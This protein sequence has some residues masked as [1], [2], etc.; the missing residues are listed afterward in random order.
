[1]P[2]HNHMC[3]AYDHDIVRLIGVGEDEHDLYY[4]V[5]PAGYAAENMWYSAVGHLYSLK[6]YLPRK[7]YD[8]LEN[9]WT[10]NEKLPTS[11]FLRVKH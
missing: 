6:P 7:A 3:I 9:L 10:I 1:M 2:F 4:I 8:R 11:R 5:Q